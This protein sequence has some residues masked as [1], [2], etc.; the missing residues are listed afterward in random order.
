MRRLYR[1]PEALYRRR[2]GWLLGRRF[3]LLTHVGRKSGRQ[4]RTVLEVLR[5]DPTIDVYIVAVGFG[6]QSN[7][8]QNLLAT[9]TASVRVGRRSVPV[10]ARQLS[11]DA[12]C[13]ELA[14]YRRAHRIAAALLGRLSG[15]GLANEEQIQATAKVLPL[16]EL[17]VVGEGA[18]P[19]VA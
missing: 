9:P 1:L 17:R 4:R 7:W 10:S 13:R 11:T 3:L 16:V 19:A 6:P 2:L 18:G 15:I 5:H 12:T 14:A 8:Y